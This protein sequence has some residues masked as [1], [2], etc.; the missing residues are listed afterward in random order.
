[1]LNVHAGAIEAAIRGC[2]VVATYGL[3]AVQLSPSTGYVEGEITFVDGSRRIFFDFVRQMA[4]ALDREKYRYHFMDAR[5]QLV[6][7][8]DN[9]A[10]HPAVATFPHH[11][12]MPVG[13]TDIPAPSFAQVIAEVETHVLGIPS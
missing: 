10:H 12:H 2:V 1:M 7:G 6:F 5:N 13:V 9:A 11:K 8:Y 4:A 3:N